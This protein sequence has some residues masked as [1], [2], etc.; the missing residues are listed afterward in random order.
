[1]FV[2]TVELL[3][4]FQEWLSC[5]SQSGLPCQYQK[6]KCH[7]RDSELVRSAMKVMYVHSLI[8]EILRQTLLIL[9]IPIKC[10]VSDALHDGAG[11]VIIGK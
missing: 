7:L 11:P 10:D 3:A 5:Q 2:L 1:M 4:Q 8:L 6:V 9:T